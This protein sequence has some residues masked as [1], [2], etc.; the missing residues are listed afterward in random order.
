[1]SLTGP[2]LR[3][4][5][6]LLN[7]SVAELAERTGLAVN[8]VR[9]AEATNG[10][11]PSTPANLT[12]LRNTLETSGVVFI[13]ADHMGPGVRLKEQHTLPRQLRRRATI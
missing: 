6:G 1:M 13:E 5:R 8:T 2:Q 10:P 3:A 11:A 4:A 9:R 7:I 12:L